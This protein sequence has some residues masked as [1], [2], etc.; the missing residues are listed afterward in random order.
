VDG[1]RALAVIP[2]LLFHAA[3]P[4]FRGGLVGVDAFSSS[5]VI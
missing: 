5:A 1:L 2:V 4:L 3:V